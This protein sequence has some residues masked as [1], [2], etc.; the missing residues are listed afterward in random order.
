MH[1]Y[2]IVKSDNNSNTSDE[3]STFDNKGESESTGHPAQAKGRPQVTTFN[4]SDRNSEW[5]DKHHNIGTAIPADEDFTTGVED[6]SW[7]GHVTH[8]LVEGKIKRKITV[9]GY[10]SYDYEDEDGETQTATVSH[11]ESKDVDFD[12]SFFWQADANLWGL[13]TADAMNGTYGTARFTGRP[14]N[15]SSSQ[16]EAMDVAKAGVEAEVPYFITVD[17]KPYIVGGGRVEKNGLATRSFTGSLDQETLEAELDKYHVQYSKADWSDPKPDAGKCSSRAAAKAAAMKKAIEVFPQKVAEIQNAIYANTHNDVC[18]LNNVVYISD[19]DSYISIGG[20]RMENGKMI[21][22]ESKYPR[23]GNTKNGKSNEYW[24]PENEIEKYDGLE[25]NLLCETSKDLNDWLISDA[26][27]EKDSN[28]EDKLNNMVEK[29]GEEFEDTDGR[30]PDRCVAASHI[31]IPVQTKNGKYYS[32]AAA[33][34]SPFM[35]EMDPGF[36][37]IKFTVDDYFSG[38]D[39]PSVKKEAIRP[40]DIGDADGEE[41][42][43]D[44]SSWTDNEPVIVHSPA[45]S[46]LVLKEGQNRTQLVKEPQAGLP[47]L[48]LD[49][50]YRMEW[51]WD[52]YFEDEYG[53]GY[54][55]PVGFTEHVVKKDVR[56]PFPVLINGVY[57]EADRDI[58]GAKAGFGEGRFTPWITVWHKDTEGTENGMYA[59]LSGTDADYTEGKTMPKFLINLYKMPIPFIFSA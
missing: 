4:L 16:G 59:P 33:E 25:E 46:P 19:N 39:S 5:Y 28:I 40:G 29:Y 49:N 6:S 17:D 14:G 8:N 20:K 3:D 36:E 44:V 10:A 12:Y 38:P 15:V 48:I 18:S 11:Q 43:D 31:H 27:E 34:Y 9:T 53:E 45:I 42:D 41:F 2:S 23:Y 24:I 30:W 51:D 35:R 57:Y 26:V 22:A 13:K 58:N 47:Q 21:D 37:V 7:Y 56:F 52:G 32:A 1:G 50:A 54:E 55:M